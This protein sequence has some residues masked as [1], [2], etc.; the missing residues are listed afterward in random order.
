MPLAL[1]ADSHRTSSPLRASIRPMSQS[2]AYQ[3]A[4]KLSSSSVNHPSST[5]QLARSARYNGSS[6]RASHAGPLSRGAKGRSLTSSRDR[7]DCPDEG[8]AEALKFGRYYYPWEGLDGDTD[9]CS[10]SPSLSSELYT[11]GPQSWMGV[12]DAGIS[13]ICHPDIDQY[14]SALQCG[15]REQQ[16][17]D[18]RLMSKRSVTNI[19][20]GKA[21]DWALAVDPISQKWYYY[22]RYGTRILDPLGRNLFL[23]IPVLSEPFMPCRV[24]RHNTRQST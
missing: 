8:S 13:E 24:T 11:G 9:G 21:E 12:S 23:R 15:G 14:R 4:L 17:E 7:T 6:A 3:P 18:H 20:G 22:N 16:R 1:T 10:L 5:T 2:I 19:I